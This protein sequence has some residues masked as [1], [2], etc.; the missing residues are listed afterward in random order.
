MNR[1]ERRAGK[2]K[3]RADAAE[4]RKASRKPKSWMPNWLR[5]ILEVIGGSGA[6]LQ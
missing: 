3:A 5:N 2:A 1:K 4:L 6:H